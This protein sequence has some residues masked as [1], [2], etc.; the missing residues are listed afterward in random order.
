MIYDIKPLF[1]GFPAQSGR[2]FLGW[3]SAFLIQVTGDHMEKKLL[4]DT[5]GYNE[6]KQLLQILRN[7]S[8]KEEDIDGVIIS[9][10]HFDHAVN[11]TFFPR[12]TIYI[13]RAELFPSDKFEDFAVPEFHREQLLNCNRLQFVAENDFIEGMK[14]LHLPGH[15]E[16]LIGLK[17]GEKFLVSDA[18]K[19]RKEINDGELTNTWDTTIARQS[20]LKIIHDAEII[21]PGHDVPLI[22]RNNEWVAT[23]DATA[24][25][26][27]AP[28]L[29]GDSNQSNVKLRIQ[30]FQK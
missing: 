4:Y 16:G 22:K 21:Y 26:H 28:G 25:I 19:N 8:I 14:I 6:R 27:F 10:L 7:N 3:S 24:T 18:I 20:I 12:A 13:H 1:H 30:P 29:L 2:G 17:I 23:K 15:T 11:W 5:G 9:H